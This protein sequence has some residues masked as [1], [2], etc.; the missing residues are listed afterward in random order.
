MGVHYTLFLCFWNFLL[1]FLKPKIQFVFVFKIA[2]KLFPWEEFSRCPCMK[3]QFHNWP[4]ISWCKKKSFG[5]TQFQFRKWEYPATFPYWAMFL[6]VP[7]FSLLYTKW[8]IGFLL[9]SPCDSFK[10]RSNQFKQVLSFPHDLLWV[11]GKLSWIFALPLV[12]SAA[13]FQSWE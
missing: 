12:G 3:F 7:G 9:L 6:S 2:F 1:K 5:Q 4:A 10:L 8:S 13:N 11:H